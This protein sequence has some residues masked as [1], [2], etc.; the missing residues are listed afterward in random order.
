MDSGEEVKCGGKIDAAIPEQEV[1]VDSGLDLKGWGWA[2]AC[3]PCC[4][5]ILCAFLL[6]LVAGLSHRHSR[7]ACPAARQLAHHL[8]SSH[9]IPGAGIPFGTDRFFSVVMLVM[10][11]LLCMRRENHCV[12]QVLVCEIL[13]KKT[14]KGEGHQR[15][16]LKISK[17]E[18][19]NQL[20]T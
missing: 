3:L 19:G 4:S 6:L 10:E 17:H 15:C 7:N 2:G 8:I 12:W 1:K 5:S 18:L 11:N 14:W 16:E 13:L 20:E 9:L